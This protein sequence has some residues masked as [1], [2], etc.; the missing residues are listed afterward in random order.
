M[1]ATTKD[2]KTAKVQITGLGN[3]GM[4]TRDNLKASAVKLINLNGFSNVRVEDVTT[5]AGVAKGLFYR[6]FTSINDITRVICEELFERVLADALA[7]PFSRDIEPSRDWLYDYVFVTVE[8]F[9]ANRGLLACMFELHGSFP[10]ISKAWQ[11]TAHSWNLQLAAF[12]ER[13]SGMNAGEAREFCYILGAAM[14]GILYQATIRNTPDLR[15]SAKSAQS[16]TDTILQLWCRAIF[17]HP[18]RDQG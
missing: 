17:P 9:V 2:N 11:T 8:K 15:K 3:K 13:A 10:E 6:Y 12:V 1:R 18:E 4:A 16:I 5:D 7:R 14:E